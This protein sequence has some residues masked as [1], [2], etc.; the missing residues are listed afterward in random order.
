MHAH[1]IDTPGRCCFETDRARSLLDPGYRDPRQAAIAATCHNGG[2]FSLEPHR[3]AWLQLL[4]GME[5]GS[6]DKQRHLLVE[7]TF[8]HHSCFNLGGFVLQRLRHSAK[9][10]AYLGRT[11]FA[12]PRAYESQFLFPLTFPNANPTLPRALF[13][14]DSIGLGV[15]GSLRGIAAARDALAMHTTTTNCGDLFRKSHP[16]PDLFSDRQCYIMHGDVSGVLGRCPW[17]VIFFNNGAHYHGDVAGY[18]RALAQFVG[19]L[20]EHSPSARLVF[21]ATTPP[22]GA[23][24]ALAAPSVCK[25]AGKFQPAARVANLNARARAVTAELGVMFSDRHAAVLPDLARYQHPCDVHFKREGYARLAESDWR[26]LQAVLSAN[27][28]PANASS[29]RAIAN[30]GPRPT[31]PP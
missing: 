3:A 4:A 19:R 14:G 24:A 8:A 22:R 9:T 23:T 2:Q 15:Y 27:D 12:G 17:D 31:R 18:G 25:N 29:T 5:E 7:E 6:C 1:V 20:R 21:A 26:A 11:R 30:D 28:D 13:M 10:P 16:N